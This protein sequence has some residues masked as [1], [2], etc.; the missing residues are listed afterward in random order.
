MSAS[1]YKRKWRA[2]LSPE[3]RQAIALRANAASR[4]RRNELKAGMSVEEYA[5]HRAKINARQMR[6]Y[7]RNPKIR[8]CIRDSNF[9]RYQEK[10]AEVLL[11][12][13]GRCANP[14]CGWNN[15]DGSKGCLDP[16]C[17][18]IDHV[19]GDGAKKRHGGEGTGAVFYRKVLKTVPGEEYQLLCANCNWIKR[20]TNG[21]LPQ[22]RAVGVG[23]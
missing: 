19:K 6:N 13:G 20:A 9:S 3:R 1:D 11:H 21:E 16:R 15:V 18:Q 12:L 10:R 7:Y 5:A 2:A 17:L 22:A 4:L 8:A 14:E 23:A